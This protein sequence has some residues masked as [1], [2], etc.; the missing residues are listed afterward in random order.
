MANVLSKLFGRGTERKNWPTYPSDAYDPHSSIKFDFDPLSFWKPRGVKLSMREALAHEL[1]FRCLEIKALAIQDALPMVQKLGS[2]NEWK[3]DRTHPALRA[4]TMPNADNTFADLLAFILLNEDI[5]GQVYLEIV[6]SSTRAVVG[7]RPLDRNTVQEMPKSGAYSFGIA[8]RYLISDIAYYNVNEGR[9]RQLE[10]QDVINIRRSDIRSPLAALSA[11]NVALDSIGMGK[12][13]TKYAN[14]YLEAGGPSGL[15]K[16][17]NR[18]LT[19]EQAQ[20]LQEK[21]WQRYNLLSG[22][23]SG[24][25]AVFDEDGDYQQIGSHLKDLDNE[26]LRMGEQAAICTALGVPGQLAQAYYAIRWGNQRAGQEVALRQLWDLTLSPLLARYRQIFDKAF[27]SQ[28]EPE[29]A[30]LTMRVFWDVSNVK[31]LQEDINAKSDRARKNYAGDVTTLNETRADM[32]LKPVPDGDKLRSQAAEERAQRQA[33]ASAALNQ[34][35]PNDNQKKSL[36]LKRKPN[37]REKLAL[38]LVTAAQ[39]SAAAGLKAILTKAREQMIADG[40]TQLAYVNDPNA[41]AIEFPAVML[42]ELTASVATAFNDGRETAQAELGGST[43]ALR[44]LATIVGLLAQILR[45]TLTN[46]V[47]AR[48]V[49]IFSRHLLRTGDEA[50]AVKLTQT[51]MRDESLVY[52]DELAQGVGFQAVA[53]GRGYEFDNNA[54]AGDRWQYS[55]ILDKNT[56]EV[57]EAAD[58]TESDKRADLPKAPNPLCEGRWR[59]RCMHVLIRV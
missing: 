1:V 19:Q 34:P 14:A 12:S 59:C 52:L 5:Y 17:K 57:C 53:E 50:E 38:P 43:K 51:E 55:A 58:L 39:D 36:E 3:D 30:G 4:L 42:G 8:G 24:R 40:L 9:M 56:C 18:T 45:H 29:K 46:Q 25:V 10:P 23:Q 54:K 37:A 49:S 28:F 31:A 26:S 35:Q 41:I 6:R 48:L 22:K 2:G 47:K 32:G 44:T 21:W 33:E 13:L 7:V 16:I 11:V 27:L 15:I 20:Q